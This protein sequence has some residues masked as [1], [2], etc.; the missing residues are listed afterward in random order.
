MVDLRMPPSLN[1]C[2]DPL[3]LPRIA[4]IGAKCSEWQLS[5]LHVKNVRGAAFVARPFSITDVNGPL[6][7]SVDGV[8]TLTYVDDQSGKFPQLRRNDFIPRLIC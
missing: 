2:V 3:K 1:V 7:T 8:D 5:A 4:D 6:R